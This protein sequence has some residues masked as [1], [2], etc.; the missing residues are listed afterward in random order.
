MK[1]RALPRSH[2]RLLA[3]VLAPV[4]AVAL[5]AGCS[6]LGDSEPT[7]SLTRYDIVH[8]VQPDP[9]WPRADWQLAVTEPQVA[10]ALD[11]LRIV[12]RPTPNE[13]QTYQG[14]RWARLPSSMVADSL[15]QSL[16]SSGR[17]AGVARQGTGISADYRLV[18]ELRRFESEYPAGDAVPRAVIDL[19]AK[20]LHV[21]DQRIVASRSFAQSVPAE[22]PAVGDVVLAF[23][24]GL[25]RNSRD[26]VGWTLAEGAR[27]Q[28]QAASP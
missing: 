1:P 14:A 13:F 11:T 5:L 10:T 6:I 26:I 23:Q 7:H 17:I 21:K 3:R 22:S 8:D 19:Q 16:E 2:S 12:V 20:L 27:Y 4:A 25:N 18:L 24:S 28:Q 9:A 15:M